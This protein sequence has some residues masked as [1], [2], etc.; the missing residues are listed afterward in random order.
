MA[1]DDRRRPPESWLPTTALR[2]TEN[3]SRVSRGVVVEPLPEL[4]G[5]ATLVVGA[6]F[7]VDSGC[8]LACEGEAVVRAVIDEHGIG[9][10]GS[11]QSRV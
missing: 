6:H 4:A 7:P 3:P 11:S 10:T 5:N 1:H 9:E 8:A 2:I